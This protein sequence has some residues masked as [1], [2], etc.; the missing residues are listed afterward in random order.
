MSTPSPA[1]KDA[2]S[3]TKADS[4]TKPGTDG[5]NGD[6]KSTAPQEGWRE[7]F[8]SLAVALILALSFRTFVAEAFV[9]PT[10]S[11]APTLMGRHRDVPCTKCGYQIRTGASIEERDGVRTNQ[12]VMAVRCPQ[13]AFENDLDPE[14]D[15]NQDSFAGDRIVVTKLAGEPKRWDVIVFKNPTAA[16]VNYIKRLIGLPN[17]HIKI[18]GGNIFVAPRKSGIVADSEYKIARKPDEKLFSMLQPV[19]ESDYPCPELIAAGWPCRWQTVA[20]GSEASADRW[21]VSE[22]QKTFSTGATNDWCEL[23]YRHFEPRPRGKGPSD[24]ETLLE[25]GAL[26]EDV[27]DWSGS[28]ITDGYMYNSHLRAQRPKDEA[29]RIEQAKWAREY[30]ANFHNNARNGEGDAY[31]GIHW[32]GDLAIECTTQVEGSTGAVA[33]DLV[34][35]GAHYRCEID[36]ANGNA[37]MTITDKDG[38]PLPFG[39]EGA[40]TKVSGKTQVRGAGT[41]RLRLSNVDDEVRL[42][43]NDRRIAFDA[44]TT[45]PSNP[46]VM[47]E[48]SNSNLGDLAPAGISAKGVAVKASHMV[49][50]RDKYYVARVSGNSENTGEY[51]R[52][53]V[54]GER[55]A[56]GDLAYIMANPNSSEIRSLIPVLLASRGSWSATMEDDQFMPLGD[57][58]PQSQDARYWYPEPYVPRRLLIGKALFVYWPHT[59]NN[60]LFWPDWRRMRPIH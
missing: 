11:M 13:C 36:V 45:Y 48:W 54:D 20:A 46:T 12:E 37:E 5:K 57:N 14:K 15:W 30:G 33:I 43:V 29:D 17:E 24:W 28:L 34:R 25:T 32:V 60:P 1:K 8:E 47:P 44:P 26:A 10:G 19:Y 41:Y 31:L 42:W 9:I 6:S 49:L 53:S 27:A 4:T 59:W 16:Q 38:K 3:A 52:L 58:S 7:T 21:T 51:R 18:E 39:D 40:P 2:T 22:D 55:I 50:S 35:G 56:E 23:R